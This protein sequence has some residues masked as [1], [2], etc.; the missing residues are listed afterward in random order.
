MAHSSVW[1]DGIGGR[2]YPDGKLAI[3]PKKPK[4]RFGTFVFCLE[5][6]LVGRE[7]FDVGWVSFEQPAYC[8][9]VCELC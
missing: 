5:R 2:N 4:L 7:L 8:V 6:E 3:H 9:V 1:D